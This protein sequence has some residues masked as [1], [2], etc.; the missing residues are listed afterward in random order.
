[1]KLFTERRVL[2]WFKNFRGEREGVDGDP[3]SQRL[4]TVR[5]PGTVATYHELLAGGLK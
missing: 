5:S 1:L 3:K 2:E 4:F